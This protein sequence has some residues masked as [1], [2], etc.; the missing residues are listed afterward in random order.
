MEMPSFYTKDDSTTVR[1]SNGT[2]VSYF[3]FNEYEIHL[4]RILPKTIQEWHK[5]NKIEETI[6]VTEGEICIKWLEEQEE[7]SKVVKKDTIIRVNKT[8]HTIAN[9]TNYP[10]TFIVYRMVPSGDDKKEII[11]NDK[12]II[13]YR[14]SL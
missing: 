6:V 8:I 5:H 10:A 2:E 9:L 7:C 11:K 14:S 1:K 3:I 13:K 12:T 4:N